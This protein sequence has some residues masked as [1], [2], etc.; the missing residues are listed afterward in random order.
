MVLIV[1]E[2]GS[3][4][5]GLEKATVR[6]LRVFVGSQDETAI[7]YE[8]QVA[9]IYRR[10]LEVKRYTLPNGFVASFIA[11]HMLTSHQIS[12]SEELEKTIDELNVGEVISK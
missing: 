6:E 4:G 9:V 2:R 10:G 8:Q 12:W 3:Y 7:R 11:E 5:G 1:R